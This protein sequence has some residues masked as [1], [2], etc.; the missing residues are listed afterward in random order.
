MNNLKTITIGLA[1]IVGLIFTGCNSGETKKTEKEVIKIGA[2]LPLTGKY[3]DLG[4]WT[5]AGILLAVE[6][7]KLSNPKYE[8][9]ILIEDAKSETKDA[10][11]AYNK[12]VNIDKATIILTTSSALSLAIKPMAIQDD[13]LF[14]AIASHPEITTNNNGK[15]FRPCNTSVEEG[16]EISN[17]IKSN[18]DF[19]KDKSYILYHNSEFGLS[20]NSQLSK[21]LGNNI[22]GSAPY[23]DNPESFKTIALK[24]VNQKP[25]VIIAIGFTP[26]LGVLIKTLRE[27]NYKGA[28]VC[29]IGF[30]TPTVI[31]LAGDA[32][33]GVYYVDYKL[34]TTS[35]H[36]VR[37]D[38][39]S[40]QQF[41]TNFT[42]IS[43]L[44][45]FTIKAIDYSITQSKSSD[46]SKIAEFLV[47][48]QK[49]TLD[50]IELTTR[51][52]GNILPQLFINEYK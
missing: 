48:P 47:K 31:K 42:S 11:T 41:K 24:A 28:I 3:S 44:S 8:Y 1:I 50:E 36:F 13:V 40:Q 9:S 26:N 43:Y 25:N 18:F 15:V 32:A 34:P 30:L 38:S 51:N 21:N 22:I 17:Y 20:F 5:K 23:D 27:A 16:E 35:K 10:V 37:L 49:I 6:D 14:F 29:N 39:I 46:I 52:N 12:L 33:K 7:L 45:Y 19:N 2:I 4:N